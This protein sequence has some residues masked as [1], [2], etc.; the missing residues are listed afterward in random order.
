MPKQES[1]IYSDLEIERRRDAALM[2]ALSTPHKRQKEMK[3][4]TRPKPKKHGG[5]QKTGASD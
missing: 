5:M 3:I 1:E 2:R 4:G